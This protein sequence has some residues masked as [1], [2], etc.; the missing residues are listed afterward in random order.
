MRN[1]L[2]INLTLDYA[3]NYDIKVVYTLVKAEE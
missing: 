2:S 3:I 1:D